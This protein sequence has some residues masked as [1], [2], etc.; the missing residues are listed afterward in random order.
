MVWY[1]MVWCGRILWRVAGGRTNC[2]C[3]RGGER[4]RARARAGFKPDWCNTAQGKQSMHCSK[5]QDCTRILLLSQT[6]TVWPGTG[7]RCLR[8][9]RARMKLVPHLPAAEARLQP[10]RAPLAAHTHGQ[11]WPSCHTWPQER[12]RKKSRCC[13]AGTSLTMRSSWQCRTSLPSLVLL[14]SLLPVISHN[15]ISFHS[16]CNTFRYCIV[17]HTGE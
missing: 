14:A 9:V 12:G 15:F 13:L 2:A 16:I 1:G 17:E 4:E 7:G 6:S 5:S 10:W 11:R 8:C 3:A